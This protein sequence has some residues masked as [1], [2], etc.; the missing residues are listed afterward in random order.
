MTP[1][2]VEHQHIPD[3]C[4]PGKLGYDGRVTHLYKQTAEQPMCARGFARPGGWIA[5]GDVG[6]D[7]ICATC[8]ERARAGLEPAKRR[9]L[10]YMPTIDPW[11]P[12]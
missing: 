6:R 4:V 2:A 9:K 8:L 5:L 10:E 12:S 7:G 11:N 1:R 3:D